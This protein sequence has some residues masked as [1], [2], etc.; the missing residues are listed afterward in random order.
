[1]NRMFYLV[2]ALA[3]LASAAG[4]REQYTIY[5]DAEYIMFSDTAAVYPVL[6]DADYFVVP[7]VSTVARRYDR[8][9]GVEIID[10]GS[11][12]IEGLHYKLM[13]NTVTIK[14][15][16]LRAD[17]KVKGN[18]DNIEPDDSLG[19]T[20]KLVM[21]DAMEFPLYG[22]TTKVV[23]MKCCPFDVNSFCGHAVVTSMF[24][25]QYSLTGKYQR[26][27]K[28]EPSDKENTVIC[29][30]LLYDGYD[31][32]LTFDNSDPLN[33]VVTLPDGQVLSDEGSVF[34]IAYGDD[35]ILVTHSTLYPSYFNSCQNY[36]AL[37]IK[38]YV[39]DLGSPIGTVGNFYNVLEWVSDEEAERLQREEGL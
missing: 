22:S 13:S 19:F 1:M 10:N 20:L 18:Y 24:L 26:L 11:N 29:K 21:D 9:I 28:T 17:V 8:T 31:V 23:L 6:K 32:E 15:G 38:A 30:G 34:G 2:A 36:V 12:A 5:S 35:R 16:E 33:P 39:E 37:W 3:L 4:C 14:A 25:Y 7:V 27:I